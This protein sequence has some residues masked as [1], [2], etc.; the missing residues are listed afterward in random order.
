MALINGV[1]EYVDPRNKYGKYS[2][3]V[4][5]LYYSTKP[6][7]ASWGNVNVG[8]TVSFDDADKKYI[9]KLVVLSGGS[10]VVSTGSSVSSEPKYTRN[11]VPVAFPVPSLHPDRSVIRQNM[12]RHATTIAISRP[13]P[14]ADEEMYN[15][16]IRIA[17]ILERYATGEQDVEA[18]MKLLGSAP[19][20]QEE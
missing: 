1:V 18:A 19:T 17:R 12:L 2:I 5:G 4:N 7:Y 3:K 11:S 15:E 14:L 6:E 9:K 8:D 10:G 20:P 13:W 16:V